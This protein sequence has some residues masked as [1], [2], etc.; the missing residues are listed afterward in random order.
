MHGFFIDNLAQKAYFLFMN[1][2][3]REFI[4]KRLNCC[5]IINIYAV[6]GFDGSV[7]WNN[8]ENRFDMEIGIDGSW[9]ECFDTFLHES[10][11]I[12]LTLNGHSYIN[13]V[14]ESKTSDIYQFMFSHPDFSE[15]CALVSI[16]MADT[17]DLLKKAWKKRHAK[18]K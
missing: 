10:F 4:G 16:L 2:K 13:R 15:I 12:V 11:E 1:K 8:K 5:T 6:D 3:A 9:R 18:G 7:S 17:L 14:C